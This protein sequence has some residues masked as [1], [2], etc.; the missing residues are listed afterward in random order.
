VSVR[1]ART[2]STYDQTW[3]EQMTRRTDPKVRIRAKPVAGFVDVAFSPVPALGALTEDVRGL[4]AKRALD[5]ALAARPG[6]R[7]DVNDARLPDMTLKRYVQLLIGEDAFLA[8]DESGPWK[9]ALAATDAPCVVG[10]VNGV[11]STGAHVDHVERRL[12]PALAAALKSKR[13][14]KSFDLKPA[15]VRARF[16][17]FVVA[18]VDKPAWD[19]Q[20]KERCVSFN[21]RG[22]A[23][24]APS[25]AF[26][27]KLAACETVAEM[28]Q[29]ELSKADKRVAAKS[30]GRMASTV[31]VPKLVD[32]TWA[33]TAR[34]KQCLLILTEGDSARTFA[35]AG[36]DALG[37]ER[38]GV[39]PLKGKPINARE[40]SA[41]QLADNEEMTHL[42][43]ILGL[44][45][46]EA[47]AGG[48]NLRYGGV[49]ILTDADA[50]GSHI[51]GLV[52]NLLHA[53]WPALAT[54]GF[55]KVSR[56]AS[57]PL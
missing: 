18:T 52:L 27:K 40:C 14:F 26:L 25:E 51:R 1:D 2:G 34:S 17:F 35:I 43:T 22:T 42:K 16:A 32:A 37:R 28:V 20:T 11:T 56:G 48:A 12:F 36:L 50:D 44:R 23:D 7:V 24:Y 8:L 47:H 4:M 57:A 21:A 10:L 41:K 49:V 6:V 29:A 38:Y 13:D 55:V 33:G 5:V 3:R 9:V 31:R 30:D 46:G 15:M 19:S 39:W 54:S 45:A 53:K